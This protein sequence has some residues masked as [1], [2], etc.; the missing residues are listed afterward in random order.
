MGIRCYYRSALVHQSA[1]MAAEALMC[2][3]DI[4]LIR[5]E[6]RR[7]SRLCNHLWHC[8][9]VTLSSLNWSLVR[10]SGDRKSV[11]LV[12]FIPKIRQSKIK[13][14]TFVWLHVAHQEIPSMSNANENRNSFSDRRWIRLRVEW[15]RLVHSRPQ[16]RK[17]SS[18]FSELQN[19]GNEL[20]IARRT[21]SCLLR[22][23]IVREMRIEKSKSW[24][25][26]T[27]DNDDVVGG[28]E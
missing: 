15:L 6:R 18:K 21:S 27:A 20:F 8:D 12:I 11:N 13:R 4:Y 5:R 26:W 24:M 14:C 19:F 2:N 3:N 17:N 9:A 16:K 22:R 10:D 1:E 23:A 7:E 28:G 25:S